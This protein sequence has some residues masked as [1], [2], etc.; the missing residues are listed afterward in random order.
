M[1]ALTPAK[2]RLLALLL[3]VLVVTVIFT[4]VIKPL[5]QQYLA[6]RDTIADLENRLEVYQRV[7]AALPENQQ[8]LAELQQNNP[9]AT[10][11]LAES[12]PSLAAAQLQQRVSQLI[13]DS[14]AQLVSTQILQTDDEG[15]LPTVAI[16][17]HMRGETQQ[18]VDLFYQIETGKP[19]MFADNIV[20]AAVTRAPPRAVRRGVRNSVQPVTAPGLDLRFDLIGYSS[21]EGM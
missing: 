11:Y 20:L 9:A 15:V 18:I 12:R 5:A 17:V 14:G 2:S 1:T 21:R 3:L 8:R 13:G 4:L 19:L 10:F 6:A 16:Q 7:S